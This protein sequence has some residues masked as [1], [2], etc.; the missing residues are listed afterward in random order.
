VHKRALDTDYTMVVRFDPE[1]A[2]PFA[3][4]LFD[5]AHDIY[6]IKSHLLRLRV[7]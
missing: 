1:M 7:K 4:A 5:N 6:H 3:L 2:Y